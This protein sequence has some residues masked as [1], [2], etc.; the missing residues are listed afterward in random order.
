MHSIWVPILLLVSMTAAEA[1]DVNVRHLGNGSA[2]IVIEGDFELGDIDKF[3]AKVAS[4]PTS[5]VAVAF[6][7]DGGSLVA[8]IRIGALIREKKYTTVI[9]D[10]ASCAS[11]CALAWLGGT[12][13]FMG[14][15]SS[16]GFHAAYI[17]KS[18]GPI[19]S[20]SGNAILGA[21][22]NQL[23]LSEEAILYIT[24]AA[25]TSI[26][27]MSLDDAGKHGIAV[28]PLSPQQATLAPTVAHHSEGS[29]E[30]RATDFVRS[31]LALGRGR[32]PRSCPSSRVCMRRRFSTTA[33]LRRGR[34]F[35]TASAFLRSVGP[36]AA[37]TIRPGSL[38]ATCVENGK[39]CRVKGVVSW[40]YTPTQKAGRAESQATNTGS[41]W[42]ATRRRSS[43]KPVP[44]TNNRRPRP[45]A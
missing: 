6:G 42:R 3:R 19:E 18:Y 38:S 16:V 31:L 29:P 10:G 28:A 2:L 9:P 30:R 17:L 14:Q 23:G 45:A 11:A 33:N 7:S 41:S 1:A 36:N 43:P 20:S 35:C 34:R 21:Y 27:W 4:L 8:G 25:P 22:L 24:Q 26:Q 39:A 13:R 40:N 12:R 32:A 44:F 5:R 37:F 15:G